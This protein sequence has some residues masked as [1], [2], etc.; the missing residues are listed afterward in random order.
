MQQQEKK[1]NRVDF[2]LKYQTMNGLYQT[3]FLMFATQC[4]IFLDEI[5]GDTNILS[6]SGSVQDKFFECAA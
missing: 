2:L 3:F 1:E 6:H 4:A 5:G